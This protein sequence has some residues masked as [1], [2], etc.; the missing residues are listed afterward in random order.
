MYLLVIM[1]FLL[2]WGMCKI[3][4]HC[5]KA[6]VLANEIKSENCDLGENFYLTSLQLLFR[7]QRTSKTWNIS[8]NGDE[9]VNLAAHVLNVLAFEQSCYIVELLYVPNIHRKQQ[10]NINKE[11]FT[12]TVRPVWIS[13]W[14]LPVPA[15]LHKDLPGVQRWFSSFKPLVSLATHCKCL[16]QACECGHW[17]LLS[18]DVVQS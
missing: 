17:A 18:S 15:P 11:L 4:S 5:V 12:V 16:L 6:Q 13:F 3:Y 14:T 10:Y 8:E 7:G 2:C 9:W 1:I